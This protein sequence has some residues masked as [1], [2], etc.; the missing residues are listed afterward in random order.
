[1]I[2]APSRDASNTS[3]FT[4]NV[5]CNVLSTG[6]L[7]SQRLA[8]QDLTITNQLVVASAV[9]ENVDTI[10]LTVD[11]VTVDQINLRN[12]L[13]EQVTLVASDV[14]TSYTMELPANTGVAGQVL[15]TDGNGVTYW[16]D[17]AG[18]GSIVSVTAGT[19]LT[20]GTITVS[21]TIA[22]DI[23]VSIAHGGTNSTAAL[24]NNRVMVSSGG[25]IVEGPSLSDGQLLIGKT[26]DV[27][28]AAYLTAGTGVVI[29][30]A[31]GSITIGLSTPVSIAN[32]G[33]NSTT[34]LNNN[35]IMVSSGG[36]IV[37]AS[38]L[39][40]GQLLI[41]SLTGPTPGYIT[42]GSG[43]SV[44]NGSG[45]ITV[46][47]QSPLPIANGG[48]NSIASLNNNR[49]MISS[50]GAIVEAGAMGN[51]FLLI[52]SS[53]NVPSI[54][55]LTAGSGISI[56]NSSGS[57]T[58]GLSAPV[59]IANG[60][61]NSTATLSN[62]RLMISSSG[63]II[64]A[65]GLTNGQLFI[66]NTGGAPSAASLT[67]GTNIAITPGA[68][69]I[70]IGLTGTV[71]VANGG[72][73]W[74]GP[75]ANNRIMVSSGGSIREASALGDGQLLI[76]STGG[77]PAPGNITAGSNVSVTN[78]SNSITIAI[79]GPISIANGGTNSSTLL[80]NNRVMVSSGGSIVVSGEMKDGQLLIGSTGGAPTVGEITAGS[81]LS[82]TKGPG[83][84]T[85]AIS[86][87]ISI[88]NGGTNS[89]TALT[90][91]NCVMVSS[92]G[93]IVEGPS[94][95]A[96]QL[97]IGVTGGLPQA[98]NL[99]AG[100]GIGISNGSGSITISLQTPVS[101]AN[102]GTNS[103]A[104]LVS[105]N[106]V[107]ISSGSAIVEGPTLSNGQLLIGRTGLTPVAASITSGTGINV[108]GGSGSI[109]IALSTPV[110]IANGGTNWTG[111]LQGNRLMWSE[112]GSIKEATALTD[113]QIFIGSTNNPPV[114]ATITAGT[115]ISV[116]GGSGTLSIGLQTPVSIANGGTNSSAALNNNRIM[117]SSSGSIVEASALIDGALLIGVSGGAPTAARITAGSG[118]SITNG[119]GSIT[120][121]L[122][123]PL[124]IANGGT[125]S[126]AVLQN[127]RIMVSSGGAIVETAS[128]LSNGQLLIGSTGAA[129]VV[130]NIT[131]GSGVSVANGAG[132]I[133]IGLTTPVSIANGG[134]NNATSVQNGNRVM[135]STGT[136][137]IESGAM[138]DGRVIIGSTGNTPSAQNI[139]GNS[140]VSVTNGAGSITIGLTYS[141]STSPTADTL[142][143]RDSSGTI[144]ARGVQVWDTTGSN[145]VTLTAP[146][147]ASNYS[148]VLPSALGASNSV[149]QSNGTST[150]WT[151]SPTLQ[152]VLL[153]GLSTS[154]ADYR[155][156]LNNSTGAI[157]KTPLEG[158]VVYADKILSN[159]N[160]PS[161]YAGSLASFDV[162]WVG[163]QYCSKVNG[164]SS[165]YNYDTFTAP[166]TGLY[167]FSVFAFKC[168]QPTNPII[169]VRVARSGS[170]IYT[171]YYTGDNSGCN[172]ICVSQEIYFPC[173][174]N[175]TV[176]F[177]S[178]SNRGST[179]PSAPTIPYAAY[180][181]N[182]QNMF[183][184]M[185]ITL[186]TVY[187]NNTVTPA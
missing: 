165:Y 96:G 75:L 141:S 46:S 166:V 121:A 105:S 28:Q 17:A 21:G 16:T 68:G 70:S 12:I 84:I 172:Q 51:G 47:L 23:P 139:T 116:S 129:P 95:S 35:C 135:L 30:P 136:Q 57:I 85:L 43:I 15:T 80:V 108:T 137:I 158:L 91:N 143:L 174:A 54:A 168:G 157:T 88:A 55:Q 161:T 119:A 36:A 122:T 127:N 132:T 118:I 142:V 31:A 140:G 77:A 183:P 167:K 149:L 22:L 110:S 72:T 104:A 145:Y 41:G 4:R 133:S 120:V 171:R 94:L 83:S 45:T 154:N 130:A 164:V 101:I 151:T 39:L 162:I 131:A 163:A 66:G 38:S 65:T 20:G 115:G 9:I 11:S 89:S 27:P 8:V 92:S 93:S 125:N 186:C 81:N 146:T 185:S 58:I 181:T 44:T 29:T 10:S 3:Y 147:G 112:S 13:N 5:S 177:Y 79:S 160:S 134:T 40:N 102:G 128:A 98:A 99:T 19:G 97:L 148:F 176:T 61:T 71:A 138:T 90:T 86:G 59:S 159:T 60:G 107:M 56:A 64:E 37:E 2:P 113:G 156:A 62:N 152:T 109:T 6:V 48:T 67:A 18:S 100:T 50:G 114:A 187:N 175:D 106:S 33:T 53:G 150:S 153:T 103:S 82:V 63:S 144:S 32:G 7:E 24:T 34:A 74:S 182:G 69:S 178:G 52:G 179:P 42:A 73:N 117:V 155:L 78:G 123:S 49:V 1:M 76:G 126:S 169:G 111:P 14:S 173:N 180:N 184:S 170:P 124:P 87:P 26:G 25:A